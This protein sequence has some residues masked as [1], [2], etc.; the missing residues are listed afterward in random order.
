MKTS[1]QTGRENTS[2]D[3]FSNWKGEYQWRPLFKLE[4]RIPV[5]PSFKL[6]GTIPVKT[7]FKLE[8]LQW[9]WRKASRLTS[10]QTGACSE[11]LECDL[12]IAS[13]T[14]SSQ[15]DGLC[16]ITPVC[17]HN[18]QWSYLNWGQITPVCTHNRQWSYL[19]WVYVAVK[20]EEVKCESSTQ[21]PL[22][23]KSNK[24]TTNQSVHHPN[25]VHT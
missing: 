18:R 24:R 16:Q 25:V 23:R 21:W 19:N 2:E 5:K 11:F 4:G 14:V 9:F 22:N 15:D 10:L 17:T 13:R 3:L 8:G 12:L 7:S 6:E 20:R 1:F